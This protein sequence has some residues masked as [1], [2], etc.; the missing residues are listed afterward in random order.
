VPR[1]RPDHARTALGAGAL[2]SA[3][4][5][6]AS[7]LAQEEM[8]TPLPENGAFDPANSHGV[9]NPPGSGQVLS[10][11]QNN[12]ST[13]GNPPASGAAKTGFDSTSARRKVQ[14]AAAKKKEPQPLPPVV[15]TRVTPV[16]RLPSAPSQP[17][18]SLAAAPIATAEAPLRPVPKPKA[19][20]LDPYEPLGIRAGS[21]I[22]KPAIE[23]GGGYDSNPGRGTKPEGSALYV[24][25]PE[26]QAQS[27]WERHEF[28]AKLRGNYTG[29]TDRSDLNKPFF[30]SVLDGRVDV[31]RQTRIELQ[32]RFTYSADAPGTPNFTAG[33]SKLTPYTNVGGTAGLFHRFNRLEIGAKASIDRTRYEDSE[34]TDG[35]TASNKDRDFHA[36]GLELRGSYEL[37]PGVKPY[38][39]LTGDKRVH[40][41]S[42]DSAG[43]RRDSDGLTPRIGTT[44]ELTR[45]LT[46]DA[47]VGYLR[48]QYQDPQLKDLTGVIADASL[49]WSATPL[50]KATFAARTSVY[51]STDPNVSGVLARDFGLQLDHSFRHWL[52]ATLKLGYGT[53]D[54][55]GI[56]RKDQR[57]MAAAGLTYK[58]NRNVQW[59]AEVRREQRD[60]DVADQNHTANIFTL[61]LRLQD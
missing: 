9:L 29:Y 13:F 3:V 47:S 25:A 46:G 28:R 15:T 36:Y 33:L 16:Q 49:V 6:A 7:A 30:E 18:Q 14:S 51:E 44:F 17:A 45:Q 59:K 39:S 35:S 57:Y 4:L 41:L 61:G 1:L 58:M 34:L 37:S 5:L 23:I 55:V 10:P 60:S 12:V 8:P 52:I 31:T 11:I 53:D 2:F 42:V 19:K 48:R 26:L 40:D 22:L 54:Y 32:N 38:V 24:I 20:E 56:A 43:I 21:F 27:D 50:T